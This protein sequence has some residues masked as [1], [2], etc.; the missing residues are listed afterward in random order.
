MQLNYSAGY[1]ITYYTADNITISFTPNQND[2]MSYIITIISN[3]SILNSQM[4]NLIFDKYLFD[5]SL[6]NSPY[7][8]HPNISNCSI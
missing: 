1:N 5:I 7:A 3:K 2:N 4:L 6:Q 8:L